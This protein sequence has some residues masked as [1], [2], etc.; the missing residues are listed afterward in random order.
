M[1]IYQPMAARLL[2]RFR[3]RNDLTLQQAS[4]LLDTSPAALSRKERGEKP[5][6]RADIRNAIDAYELTPWEAYELWLAAGF[7]PEQRKP[8]LSPK[9]VCEL[10][11]PLLS[12]IT[13]PAAVTD[14]VGY[15]KAW[16]S[17]Y[18]ALWQL[19]D[20]VPEP[21]CI[22][23]LWQRKELFLSYESWSCYALHALKLFY[24]KTLR[25]TGKAE[26]ET[27]LKRLRDIYGE[28][29]TSR[30]DRAQSHD[31][32]RS[33][34]SDFAAEGAESLLAGYRVTMVHQTNSPHGRAMAE[35]APAGFAP[36]DLA[37][38]P[39][40]IDHYAP[41]G[42]APSGS[43]PFYPPTIVNG[44]VTIPDEPLQIEYVTMESMVE[45]LTDYEMTIYLPFGTPNQ[46]RY[47]E[48]RQQIGSNQIYCV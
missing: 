35:F 21:H 48:W 45:L 2:R 26:L 20:T 44:A 24:S 3:Q 23:Q 36:A 14:G 9:S 22:E 15:I 25:A 11:R 34:L 18:E 17:E 28:E 32:R 30:W 10:V 7:V 27:V 13:Y 39:H 16:N 31:V 12:S 42:P 8:H 6:L 1:Q 5:V 40:G 47:E 43:A 46:K 33:F 19:A 29:F 4:H 38:V 37:L 41:V